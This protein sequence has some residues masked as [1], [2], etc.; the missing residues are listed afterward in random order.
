MEDDDVPMESLLPY[1]AWASEALRA[2]VLTALDHAAQHGLPGNHHFYVTFRTDYPGVTVPDRLRERYPTEM[3]IVLQHQYRD[4][5]VDFAAKRFS[6]TLSF[7][8]I[9]STLEIPVEAVTGFADPEVQFGLQFIVT[10]P[11]IAA[12]E[13]APPSAPEVEPSEAPEAGSAPVVS[14]DAFRRRTPPKS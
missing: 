9:P 11:A 2:V 14:L 7:G 13:P 12:S 6:V 1:D 4:L 10:P 8:G 3:T 5:W